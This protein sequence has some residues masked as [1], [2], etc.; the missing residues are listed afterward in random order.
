MKQ[1]WEIHEHETENDERDQCVGVEDTKEN[2]EFTIEQL[3][4]ASDRLKKK[5]EKQE[6]AT[7]SEP[8]TSKHATRQI[9]NEVLKQKECTPETWRRIR[10]KVVFLQD[11]VEEG[12]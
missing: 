4:A 2:P 3:Q 1:S 5:E 11:D 8:K 9:S 7:G 6:T 10:M 12:W